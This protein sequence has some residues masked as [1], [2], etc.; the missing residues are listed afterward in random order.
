MAPCVE[1]QDI[2]SLCSINLCLIYY[3]VKLKAFNV[4]CV[5]LQFHPSF[6][7]WRF[8]GVLSIKFH[9]MNVCSPMQFFSLVLEITL[10]FVFIHQTFTYLFWHMS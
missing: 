6:R 2:T 8:P 5:L 3:S 9:S 1:K 4:L 7:Q 10:R